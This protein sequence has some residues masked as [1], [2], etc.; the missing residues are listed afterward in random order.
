MHIRYCTASADLLNLFHCENIAISIQT[1]NNILKILRWVFTAAAEWWTGNRS[2]GLSRSKPITVYSYL[3]GAVFI[4]IVIIIRNAAA[5]RL[6]KNSHIFSFFFLGSVPQSKSRDTPYVMYAY[7]TL[8]FLA[9][10]FSVS[11][12]AA[13]SSISK[14]L[15]GAKNQWGM[16]RAPIVCG[17]RLLIKSNFQNWQCLT[18][19]IL[20]ARNIQK[21]IAKP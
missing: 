13:S 16:S 14:P 6:G 12:R 19:N 1:K 10:S 21:F 2:W 8:L 7:V 15:P 11:L 20:K 3:Q 9:P 5:P 17:N 18:S 4:V